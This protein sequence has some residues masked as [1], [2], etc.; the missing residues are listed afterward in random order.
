VRDSYAFS[1][2]RAETIGRTEIA[3]AVEAGNLAGWKRSGVVRRVRWL[4]GSEHGE[5][6]D[7]DECDENAE[8]GAID[9]WGARCAALRLLRSSR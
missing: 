7:R 6:H 4:L 2:A 5:E 8:A 9:A 3:H 1:D